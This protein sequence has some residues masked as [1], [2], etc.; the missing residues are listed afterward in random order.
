MKNMWSSFSKFVFSSVQY[1]LCLHAVVYLFKIFGKIFYSSDGRVVKAFA[2]G[3]VDLGLIPSR[4]ITM[5]LKLLFTASLL[6]AQHL[7]DDSVK[8]KP[9]AY[10]LRCWEGHL[11]GLPQLD[12][13]DRWLAT[14]KWARTAHWLLS[15]DRRS[16][17]QLNKN[18]IRKQLRYSSNWKK[19][20]FK[21]LLGFCC[22]LLQRQQC[23]I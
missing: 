20:V 7:R 10:L 4:V 5:T 11:A 14:P 16:N 22:C 23:G 19:W 1:D 17:M 21:L 8:N 18:I 6:D 3:A 9:Q 15:R 12:G 13:I 2:S